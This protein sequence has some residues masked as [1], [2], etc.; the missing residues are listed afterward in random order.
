M[1]W[2]VVSRT[3]RDGFRRGRRLGL[4]GANTVIRRIEG[5]LD[6]VD[7]IHYGGRVH[8]ERVL[9]NDLGIHAVSHEIDGT[10][11]ARY[12]VNVLCDILEARKFAT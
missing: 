10:H 2:F 1:F 6:L 5:V 7:T 9:T 11:L 12:G 3:W 4:H 8:G